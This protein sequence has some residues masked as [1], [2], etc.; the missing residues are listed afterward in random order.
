MFSSPLP[1]S[2]SCSLLFSHLHSCPFFRGSSSPPLLYL[3]TPVLIV[4]VKGERPQASTALSLHLSSPFNLSIPL[5]P[6]TSTLPFQDFFSSFFFFPYITLSVS[7]SSLLFAFISLS[8]SRSGTL[9]SPPSLPP[10]AL[11]NHEGRRELHV[12]YVVWAAASD[13]FRHERAPNA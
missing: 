3:I 4:F 13:M 8:L 7:S 11:S 1:H 2:L 9:S 5:F 6:S 12:V 10:L